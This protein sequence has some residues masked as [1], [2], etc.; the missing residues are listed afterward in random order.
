MQS[1]EDQIRQLVATWLEASKAGDTDRVLSL[2]SEDVV[3]LLPGREP[4][5][6]DEFAAASRSQGSA[7]APEIDGRSEIQ[8]ITVAGDWAFMWTR[9]TVIVT[10][11][12][13]AEPIERAGHTLTVLK[14]E[15]GKWLLHRD[16]NL[17]TPVKRA[18]T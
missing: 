5:R 6:K 12:E 16:A 15:R 11:P 1:D 18:S 17:L 7:G 9:L 2:M 10:P 4:M 14:K 13:G 8:E 3:F